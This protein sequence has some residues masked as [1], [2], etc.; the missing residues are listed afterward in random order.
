MNL[1]CFYFILSSF[2]IFAITGL[3]SSSFM[4]ADCP[5]TPPVGRT[6]DSR[7]VENNPAFSGLDSSISACPT[8]EIRSTLSSPEEVMDEI[9]NYTGLYNELIISEDGKAEM[10]K[11]KIYNPKTGVNHSFIY[12]IFTEDNWKLVKREQNRFKRGGP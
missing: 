7:H 9:R 11:W 3:D 5:N 6:F 1:L 8:S 4:E 12:F 2:V 10:E